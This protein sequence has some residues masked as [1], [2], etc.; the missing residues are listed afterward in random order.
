MPGFDGTGIISRLFKGLLGGGESA[1]QEQAPGV[2]HNPQKRP[3]DELL[4]RAAILGE[5][6]FLQVLGHIAPDLVEEFK[7][8]DKA[9]RESVL[10]ELHDDVPFEKVLDNFRNRER[11]R[12][13]IPTKQNKGVL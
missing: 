8:G 6:D 3:E 9:R 12:G 10:A 13:F 7:G 1:T 11:P 5:R 2:L 4:K